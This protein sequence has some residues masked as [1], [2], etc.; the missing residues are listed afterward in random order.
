[1][2]AQSILQQF[3]TDYTRI[4]SQHHLIIIFS[5]LIK[6]RLKF[7]LS[8]QSKRPRFFPKIQIRNNLNMCMHRLKVK[9]PNSKIMSN[10]KNH[11]RVH[12][13]KKEGNI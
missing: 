3:I 13:K 6:S 5:M 2:K 7:K 1:M 4:I 8:K 10:R 9:V 12:L 11:T